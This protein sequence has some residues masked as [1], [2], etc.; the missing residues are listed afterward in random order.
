MQKA[1]HILQAMQKLGKEGKPPTRVYR[2]LFSED[3][4][5]LAYDRIGRNKGSLTLGTEDDTADGMSMEVIRSII[6]DLRRERF[7]FRP[8]R[9]T[10]VPKKKG[11][12]RPL[13]VP[14]FREKLVQEALRLILE[15]Y[16][17]PRFRDS[18]HGFRAQ[19]ACHTALAQV[20][21]KFQG[22]VWFI[23]G[24]IRGCFDNIDHQI[25]LD[26]LS[27][28]IK[29][30]RLLNLIRL[31]L[32]A[33]YV[34]DW[35]YHKTYSGTPQG[36]ILSP[37]LANIYLHEL[38]TFIED[39]LIPQ[40]TRGKRKG[41]NLEYYRVGYHIKCAR[42][43]GDD[44]KVRQLEQYRR[45]L[46]SQDTHDPHYR[47]LQYCRYADDFILSFIGPKT[48]AED[49]KAAIGE[50]LRDK[51]HLEMND[52]KTL[53]THA[54]TEYARFLNYAISVYHSEDRLSPRAGTPVKTRGVN[55]VIRLG[56]PYGLMDEK[57]SRYMRNGK[58]IHEPALLF[59]SDGQIID[60]Y[61]QRFRGLA[62]YYKYATDRRRL[63]KL[64]HVM[65]V[66]LT[67][68]LAGKFKTTA[69]RIYKKYKG[70][71]TVD[72]YTYKTLQVE[73]PTKRGT[74]TLYWGAVPLKVVKPS[75]EPINDTI[76]RARTQQRTD[77]VQRLQAEQ[78]ELC[79]TDGQ[80]E[81]HHVR[82]LADLKKRW[83]GRKQKPEWVKRMI[84]MQRKTLVVCK[85]CHRDIHAGRSIPSSRIKSSGE[86]DDAKVSRPVR[87]GCAGKVL[88][89]K[90]LCNSLASYPTSTSIW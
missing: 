87:R 4:F 89:R 42:Q 73:V 83:R 16:Y 69:A 85:P 22:A 56:I 46:P 1:E 90:L 59:N 48:E 58:P 47:R 5:L 49:I 21:A 34:E 44:E 18:S 50:Y 75:T 65:D 8:S 10:Q 45:Q 40:H 66:S 6:E 13:G 3:L 81:V 23:E 51:L 11:G 74:M 70:T 62:Q 52:T 29:D 68:T 19:R 54:R 84:A 78:C 28:D 77:L 88:K 67:K 61:Q 35:E 72:G 41:P 79:G 76:S 32:E 71:R 20:K 14:N 63:G 31:C 80:C 64:K 24:D 2:S 33:G 82:K 53:I 86:P 7:R 27:R 17:E 55:G 15:A 43:H 26:I 9:R 25:L 12:T 60:T 38:D 30:G 36:G 39:V 57:I 37:L